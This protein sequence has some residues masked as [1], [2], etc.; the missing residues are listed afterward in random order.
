MMMKVF[1][2]TIL[3]FFVSN[4]LMAQSIK[5][6]NPDADAKAEIAAAVKKAADEHKHVFLQIGGNWCSWCIKFHRFVNGNAEI[7]NFVDENFVVVKVN[8]DQKN[9]NEEVLAS[10]GF[11]QRFGFPVFIILNAKGERVHTQNSAFLEMDKGYDHDRVLQFYKHWAP[12]ALD[13]D[14]YK[15]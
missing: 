6:Y 12:A 7:K 2:G 10:L 13:P 4:I 14:S 9:K 8:Y 15:N 11:P 1:I 3:L 5:I